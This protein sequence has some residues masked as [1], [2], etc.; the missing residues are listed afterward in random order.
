[1]ASLIWLLSGI[2]FVI[3]KKERVVDELVE[4]LVDLRVEGRDSC[5]LL[6]Q[7]KYQQFS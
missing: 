6:N 3:L 2:V 4:G 5:L 1:M 7:L